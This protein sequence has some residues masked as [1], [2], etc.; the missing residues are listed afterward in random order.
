MEAVTQKLLN[1]ES[2]GM[3]ELCDYFDLGTFMT[4]YWCSKEQHIQEVSTG[5]ALFQINAEEQHLHVRVSDINLKVLV[6][7]N[8]WTEPEF[9][10]DVGQAKITINDASIHLNLQPTNENGSLQ[11]EFYEPTFLLGD[12]QL[13]VESQS[14]LGKATELVVNKFKKFFKQELS[15]LLAWRVAKSVG[16]QLNRGLEREGKATEIGKFQ[17]RLNTTLS[18]EPVIIDKAVALPFDGSFVSQSNAFMG[19][20]G[21]PAELPRMPVWVPPKT[22]SEENTPQVQIMISSLSL[23]SLLWELHHNNLTQLEMK[24]QSTLMKTFFPNFE[25]VFG[26]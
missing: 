6:N 13:E 12:Y 26:R 21:F 22:P 23:N 11:F 4:F 25:E 7:F 8:M 14:D 9:L 20:I 5:R 16:E 24:M 15:T 10:S 1:M 2:F 3:G 19:S 18:G 17:C